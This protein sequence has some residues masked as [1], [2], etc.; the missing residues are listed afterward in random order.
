MRFKKLPRLK[1]LKECFDYDP[2][3]GNLVWRVRPYSHFP[4][5]GNA[6][7]WNS[8]FSGKV[9]SSTTSGGRPIVQ[10]NHSNFYIH[11]I[12]WKLVTGK[13]P[14]KFEVDHADT[15]NTNNSWKN[16]R[17]ATNAQNQANSSLASNNKSGIKGVSW[18]ARK[19]K[20]FAQIRSNGVLYYLGYFDDLHEAAAVVEAKRKVL[21]KEFANDGTKVVQPK[22]VDFP[23][24]EW[25]KSLDVDEELRK[26]IR[27]QRR[28]ILNGVS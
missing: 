25:L 10:L 20:W 16:L 3:T 15:D 19:N 1:F 17:L 9:L 22:Q 12:I 8:R 28:K 6:D 4:S 13:D 18:A 26:R 23:F 21:H 27:Y 24:K 2:E 11:R 5:S 7:G 14:G